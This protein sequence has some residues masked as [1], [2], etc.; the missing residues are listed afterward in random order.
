MSSGYSPLISIIV[1]VFNGV[2]TLQQCIDSIS[3]QSYVNKELIIIDGGSTDGTLELLQ[4]NNEY[5][6]YW[7]SE[8]D[9]GIYSAWNKALVQAKGE[10][11]C[12]LGADDF[13]W[14]TQVLAELAEHL[15]IIPAT[16]RVVYGKV[17]L[18]NQN[19]EN[20]YLIGEPW[21]KVKKSFTQV[22]SIPH[23]STLHHSSLFEQQGLF[24]ESFRIAGDYE[25]LLRELKTGDAVFISDI[26]MAA[27]RQGGIS[28][29]P[30]NILLSLQEV[31]RAQRLHGQR[32]PS[33]L[34]LMA[35]ARSTV[36]SFLWGVL[37]EKLTR[38]TLDLGR[39]VL[40]L[41]AFWT[42]T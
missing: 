27:M 37:G 40:G 11:I 38:K 3:Q 19:G 18:L 36:R 42:K 28:S 15:I 21:E 39:R 26:I 20:I 1:A 31:R 17:M 12:F 14:N 41:P 7:V 8:P 24:D 6:S 29:T 34:W 30:E 35:M 4:E 2:N 5:I 13:F 22:M 10:W 23:P 25:L 32:F 9:K 16:I 33:R